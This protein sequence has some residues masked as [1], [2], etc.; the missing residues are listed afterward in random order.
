[1]FTFL[2]EVQEL[3]TLLPMSDTLSDIVTFTKLVQPAKRTFIRD[4]LLGDH[5]PVKVYFPILST[6]SGI[7][8]ESN[9]GQYLKSII[10]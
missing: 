7:F 2:R 8:T 3:N 5:E 4:T 6:E 10:L 1:M 9:S